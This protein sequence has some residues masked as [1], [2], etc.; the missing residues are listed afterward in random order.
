MNRLIKKLNKIPK[1]FF[2]LNDIKKV[3]TMSEN[4]LKVTINRLV[5]SKKLLRLTRGYYTLDLSKVN[6]EKFS[7]D[8]YVP[9]YLSFEWTLS[10]Y[11][12]LSQ[13]AH[14]ITLASLRRRKKVSIGSAVIIYRQIQAKH[15]WGY[16]NINGLYIAEPEKAFLDQAYLS[17]NG[18]ALFDREEMN[19]D[20]LNKIKLKK[21]LKK[22]DNKKLEKFVSAVC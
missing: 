1:G 20:I 18:C 22:F 8:F 17:L 10:Y 6:L 7:L 4:A 21:Y 3:S 5:K 14:A 11:N 19:F 13:Q 12:I 2:T 15:F 16:K 9:S